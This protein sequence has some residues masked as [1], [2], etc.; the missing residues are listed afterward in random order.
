MTT[1]G[2]LTDG[3]TSPLLPAAAAFHASDVCVI[4]ASTDG[5]KRP[6][7][8]GPGWK[9]YETERPA[10]QQVSAWFQGGRYDGLGVVCGVVSRNLEM[11]EFEG[12]AVNEGYP[13]R[14]AAALDEHGMGDLWPR[15]T[16][17]YLE[18]TPSGGLHIFYRLDV[19]PRINTKLAR[20][21]S[22][23]EELAEWKATQQASI[24][25]EEDEKVRANRQR[26]VDRVTSGEQVPQVL[27]ETRGEGGFT[28]VAP[29]SGRTHP[30]GK[31]WRLLAG[32]PAT[33]PTITE[34]ERDALFAIATLFDTMPEKKAPPRPA[35]S[36]AGRSSDDELRPGDD[37]NAKADWADIIGPYGWTHT[38]N[39]GQTRG[40]SRPGKSRGTS[41]TTGRNGSDN[42]FVFTTG[43]EFEELKPISKFRAYT[44][45]E[46]RGDYSA[47][48]RELRRQGYGA[49]RVDADRYVSSLIAPPSNGQAGGSPKEGAAP[50]VAEMTGGAV[51]ETPASAPERP[52]I[53]IT[54]EDK[55][56]LA[57]SEVIGGSAIPGLYVRDGA[58]HQVLEVG[59]GAGR[60]LMVRAV[61]GDA[62]RMLLAQHTDCWRMKKVKEEWVSASGLPAVATA[63]AVLSRTDWP[64]VRPLAGVTSMPMVRPDGTVLSSPGYDE[65]T[66]LYYQPA[67]PIT[68]PAEVPRDADVEWARQF[69][70]HL[71][72]DFCWD[73]KAS[74]A[75]FMALLVT[76]LLRLYVGGLPPLGVISATTRG[77]GKTLLTDILKAVYG[78][79]LK[80]W[81]RR[82]DEMS[83]VI[84]STLRDDVTPVIC[85]DNVGPYDTVDHATLA[86]LLTTPEWSGRILGSTAN[87]T[88]LNDRLWT[89]TGNNVA[90][91]GDIASRSL[92]VRLDPR[93]EHPEDR[94][95]FAIDDMWSWLRSDTN[96][97][98]LLYALLVLARSW[99][100]AGAR[101]ET[102]LR[103]R[104]FSAWAK[105]MG[106]FL[107]FHGVPG[108]LANKAEM[109]TADDEETSTA[110]FLAKWYER[111]RS[112][113]Q[114]ASGL[115]SSA[116]GDVIGTTWHDPWDGAFPTRPDGKSFTDKGLARFLGA[117]RGRIFGGLVLV[118]D[119]DDHKKIWWYSVRPHEADPAGDLSLGAAES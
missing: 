9:R 44:E 92:L 71:L 86:M 102:D 33:I 87:F 23:P 32:G 2:G 67:F 88:G 103:M 83:K 109:A 57:I 1:D 94:D 50:P 12:R 16:A 47:A 27:I 36:G 110:A 116:H 30:T 97:A 118:G 17:G 58:L 29:S 78:L 101:R 93:T 80:P 4:P 3:A 49:P 10:E 41:A 59:D 85:F 54:H 106:G 7:P 63:K 95:G 66:G 112:E 5:L 117:R 51:T 42:L 105:A 56:V 104:N 84:T 81:P 99:I 35:T 76:P 79:K 82:D 53:D 26:A 45:L 19:A 100:A 61:S 68:P 24:D 40:W 108:F 96:R 98:D 75:N 90:I 28:V 55:A 65:A 18:V 14:F 31:A 37:F 8:D 34:D 115:V 52:G 43:T 15:L 70:E 60:R 77:S 119:Y 13:A 48:A 46:H 6:F 72:V 89:V 69:V 107:T 113:R 64:G 20:R 62:L 38:T 11:F 25:A 111:F 91:G 21:P 114:R 39:Y 22:T 74:K 73:S